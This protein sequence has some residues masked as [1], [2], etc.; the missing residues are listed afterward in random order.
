MTAATEARHLYDFKTAPSLIQQGWWLVKSRIANGSGSW[1]V[2]A[3]VEGE[4]RAE[5]VRDA[6]AEEANVVVID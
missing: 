2:V 1:R 4:R 6:L 3:S 5:I